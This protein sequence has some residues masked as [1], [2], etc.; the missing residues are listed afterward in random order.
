[1]TEDKSG[2]TIEDMKVIQANFEN[3]TPAHEQSPWNRNWS[4]FCCVIEVG[5]AEYLKLLYTLCMLVEP[6][7]D[8]SHWPSGHWL[9]I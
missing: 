9:G 3:I 1:M 4:T 6:W 2:L 8:S 5:Q 7:E